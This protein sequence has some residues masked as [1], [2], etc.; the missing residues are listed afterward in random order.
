MSEYSIEHD[1]IE[2]QQ[3]EEIVCILCEGKHGNNTLCQM[4]WSD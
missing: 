2:K 1:F 3:E 4:S